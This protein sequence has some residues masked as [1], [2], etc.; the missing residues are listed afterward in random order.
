MAQRLYDWASLVARTVTLGGGRVTRNL[1]FWAMRLNNIGIV[2]VS[3]EPFAEL[4]LEVKRRSPLAHTFFLGYSNGCIGYLPTPEAF[5]EG[6]MEVE[7]SIRN[8]LLPAALTPAWGPAIVETAL[9]L[10]GSLHKGK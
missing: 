1:E 9:D 7:E 5:A 2:A 4:S 6:G 10:L 8:Y 3:G